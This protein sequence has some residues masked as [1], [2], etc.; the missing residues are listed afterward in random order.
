[1]QV[2]EMNQLSMFAFIAPDGVVQTATMAYDMAGSYAIT[3]VLAKGGLGQS[4]ASLFRQGFRIVPITVTIH[5][6]GP[7]DE[8]ANLA[9]AGP[10][11]G[12]KATA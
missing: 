12:V 9:L 11:G 7:I 4:P 6:N 10:K 5:Q 2:E 8:R 1:M 3:K